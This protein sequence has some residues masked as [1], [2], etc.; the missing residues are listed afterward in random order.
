MP[1]LSDAEIEFYR[2]VLDDP[3]GKSINDLRYAYFLAAINGDLPA[4]D[5]GPVEVPGGIDA[6]GTPSATTYLRGDGSWATPTNTTYSA[7]TQAEAENSAST[8]AR[9]ATGQRIS[10]AVSAFLASVPGYSASVAQVL[11]HDD[12]GALVWTD[13]EI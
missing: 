12:A 1:T 2:S 5:T 6:T 11:E 10:Q 9:L 7:M 13:K 4:P 8:T 3:D